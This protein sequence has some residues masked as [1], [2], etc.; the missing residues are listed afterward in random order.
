MTFKYL[1]ALR[2]IGPYHHARFVSAAQL[3][4]NL[5]VIQTRPRSDEYPW[6]FDPVGPFDLENIEGAAHKEVDASSL[7]LDRQ[8]DSLIVRIKPAVIVSVGWADRAYQR[9]LLAAHRHR[10]PIVIVSDS[11]QSDDKRLVHK[12]WMKRQLLLGYSSSLVAGTESR[13][14]LRSLGFPPSAIFQPWDVVDNDFFSGASFSSSIRRPNFL[15]V[16]RMVPKKNHSC[17]L[18]A[19]ATY[20]KQ[21][22]SWGLQLVGSGPLENHIREQIKV[23]PDPSKVQC[24]PFCQLVELRELYHSA[25]AFI[26]ASTADQWGLVV[27]E[28][29]A[30]GLPCLVSRSCGCASDLI[31][32]DVTG[33]SFEPTDS[34]SLAQLMHKSEQQTL[35]QRTSMTIAAKDR[36]QGFTTAEFALGLKQSIDWA[37]ACPRVSRRSALTAEL[38]SHFS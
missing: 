17:L 24:L 16:S 23:M 8:F 4:L 7:Q 28:A 29:M 18:K 2:R 13:K 14:Y 15:C 9:L 30:V 1:L 27:N 12:E 5:T 10:I 20:Q 26:L 32:D 38:L 6:S 21:G 22:G 3:G 37:M 36:L 31:V 35:L 19:F 11:R 34:L 33:W 25:S